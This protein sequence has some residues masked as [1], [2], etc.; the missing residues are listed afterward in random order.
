MELTAGHALNNGCCMNKS[1]YND[2]NL[3]NDV[4]D[5]L[6]N[7]DLIDNCLK[8]S[9]GKQ[10]VTNDFSNN[11]SKPKNKKKRKKLKERKKSK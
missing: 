9:V 1:T 3:T 7:A 4:F 8:S 10:N 5:E 6:Q 2:I 11:F